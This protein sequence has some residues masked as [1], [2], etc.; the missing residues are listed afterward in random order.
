MFLRGK[1]DKR[2]IK[3]KIYSSRFAI[4]EAEYA[5]VASRSGCSRAKPNPCPSY[6][7]RL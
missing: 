2:D 6:P 3:D 7:L 4:P 1:N 5:S